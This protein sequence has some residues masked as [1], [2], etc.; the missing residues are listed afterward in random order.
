MAK[1]EENLNSND[2]NIRLN[3]STIAIPIDNGDDIKNNIDL[4]DRSGRRKLWRL[5]Q[6]GYYAY[7]Y[8]YYYYEFL[9][10]RLRTTLFASFQMYGRYTKELGEYAKDE[11]IRLGLK[12][13]KLKEEIGGDIHRYCRGK[14][15]SKLTAGI[16]FV[17]KHTLAKLGDDWVFLGLLGVLM[18]ILSFFVD[19]GINFINKGKRTRFMYLP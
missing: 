7:Y 6:I 19:Y 14:C 1:T 4:Y 9:Y 8:Y 11:A 3:N 12:R 5:L 10:K 17:W 2:G 13:N 16:A 15:A 18:A